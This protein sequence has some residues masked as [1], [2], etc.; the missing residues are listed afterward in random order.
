M[1]N[2]RP[3]HLTARAPAR[4]RTGWL[5]SRN[6]GVCTVVLTGA[7][8]GCSS[9]GGSGVLGLVSSE[10][11][12]A[13]ATTAAA[14]GEQ[15]GAGAAAAKADPLAR[16]MHVA[17]TVA[18]AERCGFYF[19]PE[20]IKTSYLAHEAGKGISP[21]ELKKL[22]LTYRITYAKIAKDIKEVEG[23]CSETILTEVREDL[24]PYAA[25]NFTGPIRVAKKPKKEP[26]P[27]LFKPRGA[28]PEKL[29]REQIFKPTDQKF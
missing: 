14:Q 10:S 26:T 9:T 21:D 16:P 7:L 4:A 23:Y 5:S 3:E 17:Q 11:A 29:D 19:Q 8:A 2:Q 13:T 28:G 27:W 20:T 12:K 6:V 1:N 24:P 18:R 25:G 15:A 22:E